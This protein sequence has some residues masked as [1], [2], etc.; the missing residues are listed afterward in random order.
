MT[1]PILHRII[2]YLYKCQNLWTAEQQQHKTPSKSSSEYAL[3][4]TFQYIDVVSCFCVSFFFLSLELSTHSK[5][6]S[7]KVSLNVYKHYN[8]IELCLSE[9]E[10]IYSPTDRNR[11]R[12]KD[13]LL[14][15]F[16]YTTINQL[17]VSSSTYLSRTAYQLSS[18]R[19]VAPLKSKQA[20][21]T[22]ES[23]TKKM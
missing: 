2:I 1:L 4:S 6:G 17:L 8:N 16:P 11:I 23:G 9:T 3:T 14:I 20:Q 10:H 18:L 5:Y 22:I 21:E 12:R 19:F 13:D 7:L 15:D